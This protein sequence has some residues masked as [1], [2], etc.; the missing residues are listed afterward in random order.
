[1][2]GYVYGE[3]SRMTLLQSSVFGHTSSTDRSS[4]GLRPAELSLALGEHGQ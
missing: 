2:W 3:V 4:T 1:M